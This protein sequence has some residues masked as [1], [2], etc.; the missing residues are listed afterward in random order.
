[1]LLIDNGW[2]Y[3]P[4]WSDDLLTGG[5][6]EET[7][8]LPHNVEPMPL[9][10]AD[11]DSYQKIVG[12]RR[13]LDHNFD[14]SRR[15]FLQF[16]AAG[17]IADVY[18]NGQHIAHH[19][20]GYTAFRAEITNFIDPAGDNTV[21]VKLN[22]TEDPSV[23][24]FGF[25]IDYLTYGGLYRHVWLDERNRTFLKDAWIRT[26]SCDH[27]I[28]EYT[29]DSPDDVAG[30][31]LKAEL[32]DADGSEVFCGQNQLIGPIGALDFDL[33]EMKLWSPERPDLYRAVLSLVKDGEILDQVTKTVGF[34]T[35]GTDST[36]ILLNGEPY[37]I[38]GLNRHQCYPYMGYAAP[39]SLQEED[40]RILKEELGL[41]SVRTSHYPQSHA[42]LDACDRL[43]LLVFTEI[44]GWQ[45]L[46]DGAWKDQAVQNVRE[47]V[48]E[49]RQ[50][51]SIYMWGV[52]INES[53]DDDELYKRTNR[54]AHRLDPDR[55]TSGV[56]Y[57]EK[58]SLLEDV[59]AYNDFSHNG[60][61]PGCRPKKDVTPDMNKPL[62]ITEANG[63]MFPTKAFDPWS[64]RQEH[65]L[66][67]SRVL[68]AAMADHDHAGCYQWCMF[69]YL[70]H[71]DFGSGDRV[72]YHGVMD[73]FR[74][75]K[76][77]AS[78][79]SS[80]QDDEP[81]LEIGSSMDIGD[82]PAGHIGPVFAFTNCDE[83]RLYKNGDLVKAY[84]PKPNGGMV[85]PPILIDDFIGDLLQTREGFPKA[86]ADAV[87]KCLLEIS[88][89][90]VSALP[91]KAKALLA[92]TMMRYKM[93]YEQGMELYGRYVGNWGGDATTWRFEGWKD[94][95]R[96][97]TRVKAPGRKLYLEAVQSSDE[98]KEGA[99]YDIAAVRICL[100]DENGN[101]AP[102]AQIPVRLSLE[103]PAE[104][105][106]PDI[107]VTEGGMSGT[108]VRTAGEAGIAALTLSSEGLEPVKLFFNIEII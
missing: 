100:K 95:F 54:E 55:P 78:V 88:R 98:L 102:Y 67:H 82:Y 56:R 61:T 81:V 105:I 96:V 104:L 18:F 23:P 41:N 77:A 46:G 83:V 20:T 52:R 94:G 84:R 6:F 74:N 39:D 106:G 38:R 97:I 45:H 73:T 26:P 29:A 1:M 92:S 76:L 48:T 103:G 36:N 30:L 7:V 19:G 35:I 40:A 10:Y 89:Y 65:A 59:Y 68:N 108:F 15:Y 53:L 57:L 3:T 79:Y 28:V 47:M 63:H 107:V 60:E 43:G 72:C 85:H 37:F 62:I 90:G 13:K 70:T 34:R 32:F 2:E 5:S 42:F 91:L 51:P 27:M 69:D 16:D 93:T 64:K 99:T 75:P 22:T 80:Q 87:R 17:H 50:H 71:K 86:K 66:R 101:V 44:P 9:H 33:P 58:S 14:P 4:R 8:R 11:S 49:Y 24:P 31:F 12:Y 21:I 25:V